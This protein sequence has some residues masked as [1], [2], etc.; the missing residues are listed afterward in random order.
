ME[1][2]E[3]VCV[4]WSMGLDED[5]KGEEVMCRPGLHVGHGGALCVCRLRF[6]CGAAAGKW[7]GLKYWIVWCAV[8]V[9]CTRATRHV[10]VC[11]GPEMPGGLHPPI[12]CK[13]LDVPFFPD[14]R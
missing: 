3:E 8:V 1:L 12:C 6:G 11:S 4:R 10:S 2:G 13:N 14:G 7:P 9:C 5:V